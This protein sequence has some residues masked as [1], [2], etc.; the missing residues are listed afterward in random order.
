[1][2][3]GYDQIVRLLNHLRKEFQFQFEGFAD[4]D[5]DRVAKETGLAADDARQ[6]RKRLASEPIRWQDSTDRWTEF[7]AQ[8]EN[9]HLRTLRGGRFDHILGNQADKAHAMQYLLHLYTEHESDVQWQAIA[10][11]DSPNDLTMLQIATIAVVIP[12]AS[13]KTL[14]AANHDSTLFASDPGPVGWNAAINE[15]LDRFDLP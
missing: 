9:Y 12:A 10:A 2:G 7:T 8:L 11:G 6:A 13:G 15:I 5:E 1:M 4:W 3:P 14:D